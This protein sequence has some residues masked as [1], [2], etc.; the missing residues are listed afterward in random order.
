MSHSLSYNFNFS[1]PL[2]LPLSMTTRYPSNKKTGKW[3]T[4]E[5]KSI[6]PE[7]KGDTLHDG[8]GLYG[9]V[10][11]NSNGSVSIKF[12]YA[13]KW[14]NQTKWYQCGS[15][16]ANDLSVIRTNRD[17]G[18]KLVSEGIDPRAHKVAAKIEAQNKVDQIIAANEKARADNLTFRDMY[19]FWITNGV[20]RADNNKALIMLFNKHALNP[21]G[22]IP[23]KELTDIDLSDVYEEIID[24][25]KQRTAV[26]LH[27][28]IRQMFLYCEK[29]QPWRKLMEEGNPSDLV[30]IDKYLDPDYEEE[31]DRI[32]SPDEI[33]K[34][35]NI[36]INTQREYDEA[37]NKY[38]VERPVIKETEIALWICLSTI[39][40]IGELLRT[41]W[42]HVNFEEGTWFIPKKNVKGKKR[43][44]Q[45]Q[46]VF[47]SDFA[48]A[49]FKE[50]HKLTGHTKWAFPAKHNDNHVCIK[51]VSKQ[52]G[53]RQIMLKNRKK[54]L[55]NRVNNNMLVLG[56]RDWTPHDLRRTGATMMQALK[57]SLDVIDRCQNHV[58]KGSKIR[59]HYF[60]HE[61]ADEKKEAW[62]KLGAKIEEIL[63]E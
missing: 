21:L 59:K 3:T 4:L 18:K 50:L 17:H 46:L 49:K 51:S 19:D 41:E 9:E 45:D 47:L 25:E 14:E 36:F 22:N 7:W 31:R 13:F 6:P 55:Q 57:I 44:K 52:V 38:K 40:R 1:L 37:P 39:C 35:N 33:R 8:E 12:K 63:N 27:K 10:R 62:Y 32:L 30:E 16:P 2:G 60:H 58:L 48:L 11:V 43:Q 26:M 61:Y 53:D 23:I 42:E 28:S 24:S 29:R 54:L 34:L 20:V 15:F 56:D 5:L